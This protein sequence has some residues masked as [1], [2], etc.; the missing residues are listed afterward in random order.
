MGTCTRATRG[1][2]RP[3][4][5]RTARTLPIP[6]LVETTTRTIA[7][8]QPAARRFDPW[9]AAALTLL[10]AVAAWTMAPLAS[11]ATGPIGSD[12]RFE[13]EVPIATSVTPGWTTGDVSVRLPNASAPGE[14]YDATSPGW[15]MSTN[16]INGYEV[17]VRSTTTPAMRGANAVDGKGARSSFADYK[18]ANCPCPWSGAGFQRAIF[19]YSVS[20]SSNAATPL[21]AAKWGTPSARKWRG[22]DTSSYRAYSTAGGTG[23]Y[24]MSIHL[25]SMIPDGAVQLEGSY[26][27]GVVVSAHPLT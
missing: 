3:G 6:L 9:L 23:E 16:W 4:H 10:V 11:G 26:R 24:T 1:G 7:L 13:L 27:A 15:K 18:T 17:R 5:S 25:R 2:G 20:V 21:D 12:T 14:L 22:F 8:P 19:G